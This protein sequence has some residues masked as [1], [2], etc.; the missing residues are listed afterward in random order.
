[1]SAARRSENGSSPRGRGTRGHPGAPPARARFIPARAGNT[2][3]SGCETCPGTV[4]PRAGGEHRYRYSRDSICAGSSPRGR[5]T[6]SRGLSGRARHRFIPARAGNT[7]IGAQV[8]FVAAVHPRAGG[9]HGAGFKQGRD[10]DGSSPRG[11]GTPCLRGAPLQPR[12]FI[13]ARAGNTFRLDG[14]AV[15]GTVHP[16]AGGEHAGPARAR[17]PHR[18][19]SPRGRGTQPAAGLDRAARRFIPA[20]A[21]NT[22]P[23]P[24]DRPI[25]SVHPRA[26]GEH[27][28]RAGTITKT[29]G[30][31][32]RGRGTL[33]RRGELVLVR[34]FIPARA[35]N[36]TTWAD[37]TTIEAVHPRAGGEHAG[38]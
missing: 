24:T 17:L 18:G 25:T 28:G 19:S 14:E 15:A 34:R 33:E 4:H 27:R 11:R 3:P 38:G 9:E 13:P 23:A 29:T 36:T 2:P 20:R 22:I 16:R 7:E 21:G 6:R 1:M 30:S 10:L 32:P 35:G 12:R 5:G 37:E 26:G 8:G 31:S